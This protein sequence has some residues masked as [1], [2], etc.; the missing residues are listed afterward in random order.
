MLPRKS[1]WNEVVVVAEDDT[2]HDPNDGDQGHDD[3]GGRGDE[4][5]QSD[6]LRG[7]V[8]LEVHAFGQNFFELFKFVEDQIYGYKFI[9]N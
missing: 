8:R 5:C 4:Q 3:E 2:G 7:Q 1:W 9:L 6:V